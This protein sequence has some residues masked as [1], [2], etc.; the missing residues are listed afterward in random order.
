MVSRQA[1]GLRPATL[2]TLRRHIEAVDRLLRANDAPQRAAVALSNEVRKHVDSLKDMTAT[3]AA[4]LQAALT[5]LNT[6][7]T[8]QAVA[9]KKAADTASIL[10]AR[11][12]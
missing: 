3:D 6:L 5:R 1:K 2:A 12:R 8:R 4:R 9:M 10:I 7:A 11:L